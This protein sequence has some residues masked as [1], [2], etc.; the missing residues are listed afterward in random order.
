MSSVVHILIQHTRGTVKSCQVARVLIVDICLTGREAGGW[1]RERPGNGRQSWQPHGG[2]TQQATDLSFNDASSWRQAR[3]GG[4]GI[5]ISKACVMQR[6]VFSTER[7]AIDVNNTP[8]WQQCALE[9]YWNRAWQIAFTMDL[10]LGE[11][12]AS[13]RI[14]HEFTTDLHRLGHS[15]SVA[16]RKIAELSWICLV[17]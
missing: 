14:C 17:P 4:G 13:T 8:H 9:Q 6:H 7:I 15:N 10:L 3:E 1:Q 12:K 2:R 16:N 11:P 5:E